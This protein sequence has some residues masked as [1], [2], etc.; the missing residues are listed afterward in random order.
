V[1]SVEVT[2]TPASPRVAGQPTTASAVSRDA[3]GNALA[4]RPVTWTSS[5]ETVATIDATGAV[6][7]RAAGTT[8][9][10]ATSQENAMITGLS[11]LQV[12]AP[13]AFVSATL[14]S[15]SIVTGASTTATATLRDADSVIVSNRAITWS[16]SDPTVAT[17][18]PVTGLVTGLSAGT[19]LVIALVEDVADSVPITVVGFSPPNPA[20]LPEATGQPPSAGTYGR[21]LT[22]GQTYVDPL[23][24]V[25]VLKLTDPSMP[26]GNAGIYH[27]YSEGG[28]SISQPWVG[29][30]GNIYYTIHIANAWFVD[31]RYD[32]FQPSNWRSAPS[33]GEISFAFSMNPATP[34][35]GYVVSDFTNKRVDRYNTATNQV[36]NTG[37]WPWIASAPGEF[38]GWL[39]VN[40]NDEWIA[41]FINSNQTT[42][43][44][45]PSD[46]LERAV[47]TESAGQVTNEPHLDREFP[48]LYLARGRDQPITQKIF[49]L[50]TATFLDPPDPDS[51]NADG[52]T[53]P[54]RGRAVAVSWP[55]R[56]IVE[57]SMNGVVRMAVSNPGPVD[58]NGDSHLAA[59]WVFNNP[60]DYF[61]IDQ[62]F[63]DEPHPIRQGMIG[64]V[65]ATT[66]DKRLIAA[67]DAVGEGYDTGGQPH[68]TIS[69]DGRLIMWTSNM[70]GSPRFD[71][72]VARVR[73]Q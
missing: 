7:T 46:G 31:V 9:I 2:L 5:D 45:R 20:L 67:H 50:E 71:V 44:F 16:S 63:R 65:S 37:H 22:A 39:Q 58:P 8:T 73:P 70:N 51:I 25:L 24:N 17:V 56:G 66:G 69:P 55:G 10:T 47:T 15:S 72:F 19:A 35:I 11:M 3:G 38:L 23:T 54:L 49:N 1:A 30:D 64:L 42:V 4:D 68:P 40:R 29:S 13:V 28:P 32:T 53:A 6:T 62:W 27:G 52:H 57:T 59:Q 18:H 41:G 48:I 26:T 21:T 33:H 12:L 43:A 34:R 61:V 14:G 60:N 36:E